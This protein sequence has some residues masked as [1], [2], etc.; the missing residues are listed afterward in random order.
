[1]L[2]IIIGTSS[3]FTR[4][5]PFS[6][7]FY[8]HVPSPVSFR[9]RNRCWFPRGTDPLFSI[10]KP[11]YAIASP[12]AATA[13]WENG[14][15]RL[16]AFGSM[17]FFDQNPSPRLP[18]LPYNRLYQKYVIGAIPTFYPLILPEACYVISN[19]SD[20]SPDRLLLHASYFPSKTCLSIV[21]VHVVQTTTRFAPMLRIPNRQ[22]L[23]P[24][25]YRT[26]LS[27]PKVPH[28]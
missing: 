3:G 11:A 24:L 28:L 25:R 21:T 18:A 22:N 9:Y 1:M 19:R 27:V 17:Y 12:A 13:Y 5:G 4:F 14:S 7:I 26:P 15:I 2:L 16:A 10:S 23:L 8:A 20:R 6:S